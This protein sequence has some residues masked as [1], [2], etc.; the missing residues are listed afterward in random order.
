MTPHHPLPQAFLERAQKLLSETEYAHFIQQFT[1]KHRVYFVLNPFKNDPDKTIQTLKN[2]DIDLKPHP[3]IPHFGDLTWS[4]NHT[5]KAMLTHHETH[6]LG[7]FYP[8]GLPSI[9]TVA[10]LAPQ[11]GE[12][13]LDLTAA[14]GGKTF[15]MALLMNNTGSIIANDQSKARFFKLKSNLERLN[16]TNTK[17]ELSDGRRMNKRYLTYFDKALLDAPCSCESRFNVYNPK[18]LKYWRIAKIKA[19][20]STQKQLILNAFRACKPGGQI[21]YST[22]TFAPEENEGIMHYLTKKHPNALLEKIVLSIGQDGICEWEKNQYPEGFK[23]CRI[24]P[25]EWHSGGCISKAQ[26]QL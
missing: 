7:Y 23:T 19:S 10:A 5:D 11:P 20:V 8:M 4:I 3:E 16:V 22:C 9:L 15:L 17:C 1:G 26:V 13:I 2:L 6:E 12:H 18:T 21:V 25:N 24:L 14:P